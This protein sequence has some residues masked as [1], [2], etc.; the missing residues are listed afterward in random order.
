MRL[1]AFMRKLLCIKLNYNWG[2][3]RYHRCDVFVCVLFFPV[4]IPAML[5]KNNEHMFMLVVCIGAP[6]NLSGA[7]TELKPK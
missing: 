2:H 7:Y 5:S 4:Y 3:C 6:C 1:R